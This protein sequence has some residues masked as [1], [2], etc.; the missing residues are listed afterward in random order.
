MSNNSRL[1]RVGVFYDGN[2]FAHVSNYYLHKHDRGARISISGLHEFIRNKVAENEGS[3]SRYCQIVDAHYFRGRLSAQ[4]A[5]KRNMLLGERSF[6]DVLMRAGVTTHYLPLGPNG[7]KGVDVWL[8]L[9]AFELAM[10]KRFD[11]SVLVAGDSDFLPLVRK[12]NT[13][14]TRVLLLGWDFE[15]LDADGRQRATKT[16]QALL[17]EV[18]YPVLMHQ[19]I[20]D[21]TLRNDRLVNGIFMPVVEP[22]QREALA[23]AAAATE[24][25]RSEI[26]PRPIDTEPLPTERRHG[27]VQNLLEG[28]GFIKPAD[29][30]DNLFFYNKAVSG[31]EFKALAIG[32]AVSYVLGRNAKGLCA[33]AVQLGAR[34]ATPAAAADPAS[35]LE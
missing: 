8:S 34:V 29:G 16:S 10:Y 23:S 9:E 30:G 31:A 21:R 18:T 1:T 2:F 12:L 26:A 27:V 14:G 4:E 20:D 13:L 3:D 22:R 35:T 25:N 33:E 6:D 11:V 24:R 28:Y 7:E 19:V 5:E 15:Y 17:E 32:D